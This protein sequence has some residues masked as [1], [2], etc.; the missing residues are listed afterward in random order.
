MPARPHVGWHWRSPA[1]LTPPGPFDFGGIPFPAGWIRRAGRRIS[2]SQGPK[3]RHYRRQP[4]ASAGPIFQVSI[5]SAATRPPR[6]TLRRS[7]PFTITR[8]FN[9]PGGTVNL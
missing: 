6:P 4:T 3:T 8:R 5:S 2:N 7:A 9:R 1:S